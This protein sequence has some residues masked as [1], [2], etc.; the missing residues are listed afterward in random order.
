MDSKKRLIITSTIYIILVSILLIG[1]T[2]SI[3]TSTGVDQEANVY[4]TG[5][6]VLKFENTNSVA[7]EMNGPI[8]DA[9]S[10][11]IKPYRLTVTNEGTVAY[12]FNIILESTTATDEIAHQYIM[13]KVGQLDARKLSDCKNNTLKEDVVLLPGTSADI[14]VR[15]WLSNTVQNSEM[16]KSFTAKLAIDGIAVY[17]KKTKVDNSLLAS[18]DKIASDFSY[19]N[20]V[21]NFNCTDVQCAIDAL[22]SALGGK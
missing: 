16:N 13:T 22:A 10:V 4:R 5:N 1:S 3:F 12:K 11:T 18:N 21:T 14:D 17:S 6:L 19:D 7:I 2:Y 9:K 20:S 8:S 15:I